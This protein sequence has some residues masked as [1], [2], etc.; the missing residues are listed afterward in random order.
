MINDTIKKV[1]TKKIV[2]TLT[3]TILHNLFDYIRLET[4]FWNSSFNDLSNKIVNEMWIKLFF[5]IIYLLY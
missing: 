4:L 5:S 1:L 3:Y 2:P